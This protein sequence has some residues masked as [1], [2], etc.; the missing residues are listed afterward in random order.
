[1]S[2]TTPNETDIRQA[3]YT[4]IDPE[5]GMNVVDLG[6][7]YGIASAAGLVHIT[8]TMTTPACPMG[9]YLTE[10]VRA[11]AQSAV[12]DGVEIEVELVWDPPWHAGMMSEQA[13]RFFGRPGA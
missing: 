9:S 11:A 4:V 8:M 13:K 12:P 3:L 7:I 5:V 6:L 1:M 10:N 2:D